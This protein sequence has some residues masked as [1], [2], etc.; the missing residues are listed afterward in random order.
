[1]NSLDVLILSIVSLLGLVFCAC[2]LFAGILWLCW[3]IYR[4]VVGW[5]VIWK[6]LTELKRLEK[7]NSRL[8]YAIDQIGF[9][10]AGT[11]DDPISK[12]CLAV[13]RGESYN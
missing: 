7:E 4:N 2:G 12:R 13:L 10:F 1:M 9:K 11:T 5:P 8:R 6:A 3:Y